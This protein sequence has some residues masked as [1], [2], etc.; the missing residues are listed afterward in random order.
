MRLA[1]T[2]LDGPDPAL[3]RPIVTITIQD[4]DIAASDLFLVFG[5][6]GPLGI[7][8]GYS[9]TGKLVSLAIADDKA[10]RIIEFSQ[11]KNGNKRADSNR[12]ASLALNPEGRQMLQDRILCRTT[13]DIFAFD[14][15]PLAMSLYCDLELRI[16]NAVDIQSA[17]SAVD[18]KPLTGIKAALGDSVRIIE[19][20]VTDVFLN[21]IYNIEDK[22]RI[23]DLAQRAWVSQFLVGC[24]NGAAMFDKVK[25]IDTRKL[26]STVS[27]LV[28]AIFMSCSTSH[29]LAPEDDRQGCQRCSS[30]GP[31]ET[32]TNN[33]PCQSVIRSS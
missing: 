24:G 18:R 33:P 19:G 12:K 28:F 31:K 27:H 13:G 32:I 25:R 11:P 22:N 4:I 26:D 21:P 7:S 10:C 20:N 29:T 14:M 3:N 17:F 5:H 1:Q 6:A 9:A 30:P 8:P 16:T 23:T 15:G 2:I